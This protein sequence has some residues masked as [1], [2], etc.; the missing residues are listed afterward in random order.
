MFMY[1]KSG[2]LDPATLGSLIQIIPSGDFVR[3]DRRGRYVCLIYKESPDIVERFNYL[4]V[5]VTL[6]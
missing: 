3:S 2:F 1:V 4:R 6:Q 5:I